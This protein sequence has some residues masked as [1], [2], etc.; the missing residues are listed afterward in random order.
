MRVRVC[1]VPPKRMLKHYV[2]LEWY[3]LGGPI[4]PP[5]DHHG[6]SA[7]LPPPVRRAFTELFGIHKRRK[8]TYIC[9]HF[10]CEMLFTIAGLQGIYVP[11]SLWEIV[12]Y[13][14]VSLYVGI[15]PL[16]IETEHPQGWKIAIT[17]A[18]LSQYRLIGDITP[19]VRELL[20]LI[21]SEN[22]YAFVLDR[23]NVV[24]FAEE[25]LRV[26]VAFPSKRSQGFSS[27]YMYADLV[28]AYDGRKI[29]IGLRSEE[30]LHLFGPTGLLSLA[31]VLGDGWGGRSILICSPRSQ[32]MS[33]PQLMEV[34]SKVLRFLKGGRDVRFIRNSRHRT[35]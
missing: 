11:Q 32:K 3:E 31:S 19:L 14:D 33:L 8:V 12:E 18:I 5:L 4:Q 29:S 23:P 34:V 9:N 15:R 22:I 27:F 6:E 16:F 25:P 24:L 35:C 21:K 13:R 17:N 26:G 1:T 2:P 20:R 30:Y 28:I 10:D 7:Y